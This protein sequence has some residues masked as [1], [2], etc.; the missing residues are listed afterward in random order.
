MVD[1]AVLRRFS[2]G[3]ARY[4]AHAHA[5]RLSAVDLL[6]YT[7]G[8]LTPARPSHIPEPASKGGPVFKILEPGCGTGLYTRM[9]LD[10]FRGASV[11]GVD[12]SEAMVRVAKRGIDDPRARFAVA[13][14]EE[15]ATGSYDLVTS[16]AAFQWFLSFPRTLARMA[17]LLARGGLLSFSF[18]GPET[19]AELDAALRASAI[20]GGA[21][22]GARVAAAA[23][24]TREEISD[25]LSAAFP[26]WDVAERRYRQG[27]PT[28]AD[29]L[30][31]IR[32]TGTRGG[33]ARESWSPGKLARV[34]EAYREREGG[35]EATYQVFLCRGV[36]PGGGTG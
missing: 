1:P 33:G 26:R 36:I 17:S 21:H 12:I 29:L 13:D 28:L 8:S 19:Y 14:A 10:A 34:E 23:F 30:R 24:H 7:K 15:I 2:A 35:I 27:F 31:S 32:Y 16:N 5:Q 20:R 11:F 6:A 22:D 25:A 9:L 3:A 18:F 4:E